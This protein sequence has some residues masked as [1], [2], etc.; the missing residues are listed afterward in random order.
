MIAQ[1]VMLAAKTAIDK[2][3]KRSQEG[4]FTRCR[5]GITGMKQQRHNGHSQVCTYAEKVKN[6]LHNSDI[7]KTKTKDSCE[8]KNIRHRQNFLKE[9]EDNNQTIKS[10]QFCQIKRYK[11]EK[12]EEW[13]ERVRLAAIECEYEKQER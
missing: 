4:V 11:C 8:A 3:L 10:V 6:S 1:I 13:I 12:M 2:I 9:N 5:G 7:F